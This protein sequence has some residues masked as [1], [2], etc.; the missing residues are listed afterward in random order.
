MSPDAIAAALA[1]LPMRSYD[2]LASRSLTRPPAAPGFYAWWQRPGAVP[3]VPGTRHPTAQLEL[4]YLGIAPDSES[5][6][7]NL[8]TRLGQH[9]HAAVGSSTF[10]RALTA[11]LWQ[12]SGWQLG[13]R[14]DR[15]W[16]DKPHLAALANWQHEHLLVQWVE[17]EKPW[18]PDLESAVIKLMGPPL[19]WQHNQHHPFWPILDSTRAAL[20]RAA[21]EAT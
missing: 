17:V 4:L 12:G 13:W 10:R 11:F 2:E 7:S 1:S 3:G 14:S 20:A 18:R 9:H 6:K 5:S 19:N 21:R 15:V 16:L 8:R